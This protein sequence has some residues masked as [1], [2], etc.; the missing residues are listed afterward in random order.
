MVHFKIEMMFQIPAVS[1]LYLVS[2]LKAMLP[3]RGN[4]LWLSLHTG[5]QP[6]NS[7]QQNKQA[8]KYYLQEF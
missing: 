1:P 8:Y 2:I 6:L 5:I 7:R 3:Q 4:V